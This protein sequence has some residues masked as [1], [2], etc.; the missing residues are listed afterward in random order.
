VISSV[1]VGSD[2][3][4]F[5]FEPEPNNFE[6]LRK[7]ILLGRLKNIS[8]FKLALSD[9]DGFEFMYLSEHPSMHSLVLKRSHRKISVPVMK[10]DTIVKLLKIRKLDLI[11][12]DVEGAELKV[13]K[14]CKRLI[15]E[16]KPIFSIDVNHYDGEFEE[17]QALMR[18][19]NYEI[20]P[21]FG[22]TGKLH[23]IVAYPAIKRSLVDHLIN[24]TR[25]LSIIPPKVEP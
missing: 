13:L 20:R 7:V 17:V 11:K 15:N 6:I 2:G 3:H 18:E 14:G 23:S 8:A 24:K 5:S 19:F 9:S 4:V 16:F 21:L 12:I 22:E 10:M 25:K 1:L